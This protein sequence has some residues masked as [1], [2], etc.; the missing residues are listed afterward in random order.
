MLDEVIQIWWQGT[1]KNCERKRWKINCLGLKKKDKK[2][3]YSFKHK[4]QNEAKK[5]IETREDQR[6]Q[7]DERRDGKGREKK[8]NQPK[9][10]T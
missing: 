7:M 6:L 2:E 4:K 5:K 9:Y 10:L 1:K 3:K 8:R